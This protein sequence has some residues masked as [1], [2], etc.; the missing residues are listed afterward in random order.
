MYIYLISVEVHNIPEFLNS[1]YVRKY[2][3]TIYYKKWFYSVNYF[4]PFLSVS[5]LSLRSFSLLFFR[6]PKGLPLLGSRCHHVV[7]MSLRLV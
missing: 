3:S 1:K 7:R 6:Y 4:F 2:F 5:I